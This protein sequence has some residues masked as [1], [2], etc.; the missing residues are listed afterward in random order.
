[1]KVELFVMCDAAT[2][3]Q[4]KLNILGT[5]DAIWARS[6][7]VTHPLCALALRLRFSEEEEGEHKVTINILD[8]DGKPVV[9]SF[10]PAVNVQFKEGALKSVA[11]NMILNIQ[12]IKF[13]DY[14]AYSIDL[15][16]DGTHEASLP[17]Y[18]NE[19]PEQKSG[20]N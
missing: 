18:L 13:S 5:F 16:V 8:E 10:E 12:G 4:G 20:M 9:R 14:G 1:M 6:L 2:E 17:L 19:A 7:P 15:S 3:Y 11:V